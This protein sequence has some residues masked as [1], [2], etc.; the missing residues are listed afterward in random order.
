MI[1]VTSVGNIKCLDWAIRQCYLGVAPIVVH[2]SSDL[3]YCIC[4]SFLRSLLSLTIN[5]EQFLCFVWILM[6]EF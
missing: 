6:Y 2:G 4:E 5:E 3:C 1:G